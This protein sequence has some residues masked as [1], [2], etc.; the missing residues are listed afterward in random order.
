MPKPQYGYDHQ[1]ARKQ[2]LA[3]FR[4]GTPCPLCGF[5][6]R[7]WQS[8]DLNHVVPVKFGGT[9]GKKE[10]THRYCNRAEGSRI[11]YARRNRIRRYRIRNGQQIS[12]GSR[13]R[14]GYR[15]DGSPPEDGIRP[16]KGTRI[17]PKW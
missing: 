17:L 13:I 8:L 1:L 14:D 15:I 5:P 16:S 4:D 9:D 12:S 11:R 6:M 3:E 2:A 7:V 10:L